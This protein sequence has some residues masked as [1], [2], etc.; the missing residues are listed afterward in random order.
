MPN[1]SNKICYHRF[2]LPASD[3]KS[4][5]GCLGGQEFGYGSVR[6]R[7][8]SCLSFQADLHSAILSV[9]LDPAPTKQKAVLLATDTEVSIAPKLRPN[10]TQTIGPS[11]GPSAVTKSEPSLDSGK[12][13]SRALLRVLPSC[14]FTFS[15]VA[16][17]DKVAWVSGSTFC[18]LTSR[19]YPPPR[20]YTLTRR[21]VVLHRLRPP[22]APA[23][24]DAAPVPPTAVPIS[25]IL[26][27]AEAGQK[28]VHDVKIESGSDKEREQFILRWAENLPDRH[29]V[30]EQVPSD[31]QDWDLIW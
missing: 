4:M 18:H 9:S 25:R 17:Q 14:L 13:Y 28:P 27:T 5:F 22:P 15:G 29:V 16:S 12:R 21:Y 3:K 2:V 1:T 11:A 26:H 31:V 7:Y 30:F 24:R 6:L 20:S 19:K 23:T 8:V 10:S